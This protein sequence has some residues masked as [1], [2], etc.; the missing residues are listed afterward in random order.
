MFEAA[1]KA[2][3]DANIDPRKDVSSFISCD[4]DFWEGWS[5]TDE[6]VP[7]Q[8]GGA[9]RAVSR[10]SADGLIGIAQAAMQISSGIGDIVVVEAHSKAA[11]VISKDEVEML[12]LEPSYVRPILTL[13]S[14]A[15]LEMS[16]YM[17]GR[18]LDR[19]CLIRLWQ[20]R[21]TGA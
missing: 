10:V 2:Y 15:A 14:L 13:D 5:I 1:S 8:I 18:K 6:M 20:L 12:S 17:N 9:R 3:N 19:N 7:D 16:Y 11:D 4:E 21:R